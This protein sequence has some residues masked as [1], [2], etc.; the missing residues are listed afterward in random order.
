MRRRKTRSIN[1]QRTEP[2]AGIRVSAA[3]AVSLQSQ[4]RQQVIEHILAG[5]F[6]PG[7]RLP[8]S[9]KLSLQLGVAR[10]TVLLA[11]QGL[12]EQGHLIARARSGLYLNESLAKGPNAEVR[13]G[14]PVRPAAR[15]DWSRHLR[16][17]GAQLSRQQYPS[18]WQGYAYPFIEGCFDRSL[19][20]GLEWRHASRAALTP[21][22]IERWSTDSEE[23]DDPQLIHEIRTKLLPRR[24]ISASADEIMVTAGAEQALHLATE[25]LVKRGTSVAVEEPGHVAMRELVKQHR[26]KLLLQAVDDSGLIVSSALDR[27]EVV[28]VTPSHQ[29]PTA[30]TLSLERRTA[31]LDK[32]REREFVIL[33]DDVDSAIN[34]LENA[35]PALRALPGGERVVYMSDFSRILAPAVRLGYLVADPE[36]I[37]AARR[38]RTLYSRHPPLISQRILA[39]LLASGDYDVAMLRLARL[40]RERLMAL[41]DA[42]NHYLQRFIAIAPARG[43]TTYWVRGP[44]G[45][46]ATDLARLAAQRGILIEPVAPY[47]ARTNR[48]RNLFRLGI[49]G[50]PLER[51]RSGVAELAEL[52]RGMDRKTQRAARVK[53][54]RWLDGEALRRQMSGASI[55]CKTIYGHPCTIELRENGRMVGRA[56]YAD[57]DRDE[58][59]W[60]IDGDRWFRQWRHWSYAEPTGFFIRVQGEHIQWFNER[61]QLV[62]AAIFAPAGRKS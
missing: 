42:L 39:L 30:V 7:Q 59:R 60:W 53:S 16:N 4:I 56:G 26:G 24:G 25:L 11:Y 36:L 62:D 29:R 12:I 31:L 51:I 21:R 38:L 44:K 57:E 41:R 10:N 15:A 43:G 58:G 6:P 46:D 3:A 34:Y 22:Q 19:F 61:H 50:V 8:S 54:H 17:A 37:A 32:A 28:Y 14:G 48:H 18:N 1:Q 5:Q 33:E 55:L 47:F 9:R 49:T 13:I 52:L 40:F 45:I 23:A 2:Q 35:P 20:P 27:S